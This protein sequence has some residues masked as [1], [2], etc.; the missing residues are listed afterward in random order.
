MKGL[1]KHKI[2]SSLLLFLLLFFGFPFLKTDVSANVIKQIEIEATI[3]EDGSIIIK[4]RRVLEASRGTEHYISLG[5]LGSSEL[6]SFSVY[7]DDIAFENIGEWDSSKSIEEKKA[8]CGVIRKK[9]SLELCFGI[10]SLGSH[11]F[12]MVYHF[13]NAVRNLKDGKQALYWEFVQPNN[14]SEIQSIRVAVKNTEGFSYTED[15]TRIWGFGYPGG[16]KIT[17][18]ALEMWTEGNIKKEHYVV[19]LAIFPENSFAVTANSNYSSDGL[20]KKAKEGSIWG[21]KKSVGKSILSS[22]YIWGIP[23]VIFLLLVGHSVFRGKRRRFIK[24]E[25]MPTVGEGEYYRKIPYEGEILSA[26][27]L[28]SIKHEDLINALI[29][30]WIR[31]GYVKTV[32]YQGGRLFKK[33]RTGLAFNEEAPFAEDAQTEKKLWSMLKGASGED[34]IL[35]QNELRKYLKVNFENFN[36]WKEDSYAFSQKH[37]LKEKLLSEM[38]YQFLFW[39][40]KVHIPSEEGRVVINRVEAFKNY[41]LDFSILDEREA[42]NVFIWDDYMIWAALLGITDKVRAQFNLAYPDYSEQSSF[43]DDNYDTASGFSHYLVTTVD[44]LLAKEARRSEDGG[45]GSSSSVG[46]GSG[47]TGSSSGGGIR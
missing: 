37:M 13:S 10:G 41:L 4:D 35:E 36:Q 32:D 38:T 47:A 28:L 39:K 43:D 1:K 19:L 20:I 22:W 21:S 5:N 18:K 2:L 23:L 11:D 7:E 27:S 3:Q 8:K 31:K 9:D 6:L 17:E 44:H 40:D 24:Q 33:T 15:N 30:K 46:G 29:L 14:L 34:R 16:T 42:Y 25:M 26:L 45:G 12:T